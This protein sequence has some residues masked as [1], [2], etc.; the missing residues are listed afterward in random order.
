MMAVTGEGL[1][2]S[3]TIRYQHQIMIELIN[4]GAEK[5][6]QSGNSEVMRI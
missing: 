6:L 3:A 5:W 4:N 2:Y 1:L